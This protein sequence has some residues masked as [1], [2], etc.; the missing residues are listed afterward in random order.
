MDLTDAAYILSCDASRVRDEET[1][2]E[3]VPFAG[4]ENIAGWKS[5]TPIA[6]PD[7]IEFEANVKTLREVD[8][9]DN[10]VSWPIMS[11]RMRAILLP[12][13]ARHRVIPVV[14]LDDSIPPDR[15]NATIDGFAAVQ[16][17]ELTAAMD[18]ERSVYTPDEDFPGCARWIKKLVLEV[19]AL[20]W[21]FRLAP[22]QGPLF[23]S[24]AA[25]VAL[26]AAKVT[27]VRFFDLAK[28]FL[29]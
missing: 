19:V 1:T 13:A 17:L 8:Y 27:G 18:M 25:R 24:H 4:W 9:P 28:I 23:V 22:Y 29:L 15:R 6:L 26:E 10:S 21:L 5:T 20:P 7:R 14:M 16:L 3:L 11:E 2:A 12:H